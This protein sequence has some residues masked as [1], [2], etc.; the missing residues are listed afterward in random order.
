MKEKEQFLKSLTMHSFHNTFGKRQKQLI[1][2]NYVHTI[3]T[4]HSAANWVCNSP[5][6]GE[7]KLK[8]E[9][10]CTVFMT[11]RLVPLPLCF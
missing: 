11:V 3:I 9:S 7:K 6:G 5:C 2:S 8:N 10:F 1:A 4:N